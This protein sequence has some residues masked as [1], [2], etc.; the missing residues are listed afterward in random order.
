MYSTDKNMGRKKFHRINCSAQL[1]NA[2][3]VFGKILIKSASGDKII[4]SHR[5]GIRMMVKTSAMSIEK[6]TMKSKIAEKNNCGM[7]VKSLFA[8]TVSHC[9]GLRNCPMRSAKSPIAVMNIAFSDCV[10]VM[11][12]LQR[13]RLK[14]MSNAATTKR[15]IRWPGS[16]PSSHGTL[17]IMANA[18]TIIITMKNILEKSRTILHVSLIT[19]TEGSRRKLM[20]QCK[21]VT[22][23]DNKR[24][25]SLNIQKNPVLIT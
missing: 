2:F 3:R 10:P 9:D 12:R 6:S 22:R 24:A 16:Y 19:A 13:T 21:A 11:T 1:S 23:S 14:L 18:I 25:A 17:K 20:V 5:N 4:K 8:A 7:V 15:T